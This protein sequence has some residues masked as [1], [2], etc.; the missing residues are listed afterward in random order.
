MIDSYGLIALAANRSSA[1]EELGLVA[2]DGVTLTPIDDDGSP[3]A[4][5]VNIG[6]GRARD[7]GRWGSGQ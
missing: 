6:L 4:I 2:G 1:A 5:A 3:D 7:G